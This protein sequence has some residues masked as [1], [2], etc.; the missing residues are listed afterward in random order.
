MRRFCG[1]QA[2]PA[3][4]AA[5]INGASATFGPVP[6]IAAVNSLLLQALLD[7]GH[8][9][10]L[11]PGIYPF[12]AEIEL[13]RHL[14]IRGAGR[15]QTLLW[16]P[17]S[18]AFNVASV[19]MIYPRIKDLTI[20]ASGN[21]LRI[22]AA[23]INGVHGLLIEDAA[24]VSYADHAI[25]SDKSGVPP[26][27]DPAPMYGA[28]FTNVG[29]SAGPGKAATFEWQSGSNVF[30]DVVDQHLFFDG[31]QT[32]AKGVMRAFHWNTDVHLHR[33]S[34]LCYGGMD[35]FYLFE[36]PGFPAHLGMDGNTFEGNAHAFEAICKTE[37]DNF[38][39]TARFNKYL[40]T[41]HEN[42]HHF[43]FNNLNTYVVEEDCPTAL[44]DTKISIRNI[45]P[46]PVRAVSGLVDPVAGPQVSR[47]LMYYGP[48]AYSRDLTVAPQTFT[49]RWATADFQAAV[50]AAH[51]NAEATRYGAEVS[52]MQ[53]R[54]WSN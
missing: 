37:V 32:T 1:I 24:L 36:K 46:K 33:N 35:Y 8:A 23:E 29:I 21:V 11:G 15:G 43:I 3:D 44:Y 49:Y 47:R 54:E 7:E 5:F 30:D 22:D 53:V 19:G 2:N 48:E 39:L 26:G 27:D 4:Y 10:R 34:N 12:D 51:M 52:G 14:D 20:E 13:S 17:Q 41:P 25:M 6:T 28:R 50:T 9:V 42:G 16:F 45:G 18:R 40:T 31:S 38:Y